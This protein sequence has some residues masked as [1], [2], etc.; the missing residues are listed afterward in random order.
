MRRIDRKIAAL[1]IVMVIAAV[2]LLAISFLKIEWAAHLVDAYEVGVNILTGVTAII[3]IYSVLKIK[4]ALKEVGNTLPNNRSTILAHAV[5][6]A[7]YGTL[8][9]VGY[10]GLGLVAGIELEAYPDDA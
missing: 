1:N 9:L 7:T 4:S 5:L 3:L 2:T 8:K 10:L 6:F